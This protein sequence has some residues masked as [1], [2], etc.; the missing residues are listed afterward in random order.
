MFPRMPCPPNCKVARAGGNLSFVRMA[1]NPPRAVVGG[2]KRVSA[3][4]GIGCTFAALAQ[5]YWWF[6]VANK[7]KARQDRH[8]PRRHA[9]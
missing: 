4:F 2:C 8:N 1:D 7:T 5:G 9:R 3:V 6:A